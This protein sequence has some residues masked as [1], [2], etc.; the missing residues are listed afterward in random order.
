VHRKTWTKDGDPELFWPQQWLSRDHDFRDVRIHTF[1]YDA[2]WDKESILNIHDFAKDLLGW[3]KDSPTIPREDDV[4][5]SWNFM[6]LP[7]HSDN[8]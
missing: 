3:L 5:D 8:S 6:H 1:G 2:N 7:K 4:S